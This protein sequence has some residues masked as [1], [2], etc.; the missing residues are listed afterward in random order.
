[1]DSGGCRELMRIPVIDGIAVYVYDDEDVAPGSVHNYRVYLDRGLGMEMLFETG[2]LEV[3]VVPA[4]LFQNHPNP[5]NPGTTIG[6][7]LPS[8]SRVRIT[9]YDL[10]GR[11]VRHLVDDQFEAGVNSTD[12]DGTRDAGDAAVSGVYFYRIEAG[13][14]TDSKKMVILR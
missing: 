4:S 7:Y 8:A 3:P 9:I 6:W 2:E 11:P 12:W 5:L 13:Q 10:A 14:F 1:M